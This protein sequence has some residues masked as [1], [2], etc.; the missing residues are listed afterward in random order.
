MVFFR[1]Q[2]ILI[3]SFLSNLMNIFLGFSYVNSFLVPAE[4]FTRCASTI[5]PISFDVVWSRV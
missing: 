3:L 5:G 2:S 4:P 1:R